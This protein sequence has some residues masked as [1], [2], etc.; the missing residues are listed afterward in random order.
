MQ[1]IIA[2]SI[3]GS[4]KTVLIERIE[5]VDKFAAVTIAAMPMT[6]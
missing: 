4:K 6:K 2:H 3:S 1:Q 5:L